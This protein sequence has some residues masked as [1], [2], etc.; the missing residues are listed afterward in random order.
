MRK[1]N[2]Y[3]LVILLFFINLLFS[4]FYNLDIEKIISTAI[5]KNTKVPEY[6]IF[7][8]IRIPR[9][10]ATHVVGAGLAVVGCVLQS[11]FLNP[12]C[13]GYTLGI[14]SCAGLGVILS[15]FLDLPFS[16][17][18]SSFLGVVFSMFFMFFLIFY[19]KRTI[20]I[21]FVLTGIVINFLFSGLIILLTILLDPYRINYILLWL[22]GSF[23]SLE[24]KYVYFSSLVIVTG[25]IILIFY[26][27]NIDLIVLG[28]EKSITLGVNEIKVKNLLLF[29]CILI[30][31]MCVSL[32][33]V[34]SFVGVVI[35]N[36]IKSFTGLKHRSWLI[37]SSIAG[38]FF[39]SLC[40]NLAKNLFYPIEVP[41]SVF[42]GI[43]GS[44]FFVVYIIKGNIHGNI[45]S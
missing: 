12:L 39:V 9:S 29:I 27:H 38:G 5:I 20:D 15:M 33:G 37:W 19:F 43:I 21:S 13:E 32:S 17:F 42:T 36:I 35:P 2:F 44:L 24:N 18:V 41:I 28:K 4:W 45:K 8:Q 25:L 1:K 26:S 30:L 16:K 40:D 3:F 14:A 34:I 6:K 7:F 22:L 11:I 23:S 10:L 31:S